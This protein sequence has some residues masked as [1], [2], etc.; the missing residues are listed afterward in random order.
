MPEQ[1]QN[2]I[3]ARL[4]GG[5]EPD[6]I[7][8]CDI[9]IVETKTRRILKRFFIV[10]IIEYKCKGNARLF[11]EKIIELHTK[12]ILSEEN[13]NITWPVKTIIDC[14]ENITYEPPQF[15]W[16]YSVDLINIMQSGL[17]DGQIGNNSIVMKTSRPILM[18]KVKPHLDLSLEDG[19]SA[20]V[21][22]VDNSDLAKEMKASLKSIVIKP[23]VKASDE[24]IVQAH[25]RKD[26]LS[27][28][29]CVGIYEASK[30]LGFSGTFEQPNIP[31]I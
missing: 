13:N 2:L 30:G 16:E 25:N 8:Q 21:V 6:L 26:A 10:K 15:D 12:L 22:F 31:V 24:L 29:L 17:W 19:Q 11:N 18:N 5:I 23:R 1:K 4:G 20:R 9:R 28:L 14:S 27:L 3:V 7:M